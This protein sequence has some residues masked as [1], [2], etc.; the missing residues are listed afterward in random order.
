[1][2]KIMYL[3]LVVS[4][5]SLSLLGCS[6]KDSNLLTKEHYLS[7]IKLND[8]V[9][10]R[11]IDLSKIENLEFKKEINDLSKANGVYSYDNESYGLF[12][13]NK[14]KK[15]ILFNGIEGS[16]SD[17]TFSLENKILTI[18]YN[19]NTEKGLNKNSLFVVDDSNKDISY[20]QVDLYKDGHQDA[21]ETI[22]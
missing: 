2:K 13:N 19:Y 3:L 8:N 16:Y 15:M 5:M 20:D 12:S 1:M 11:E 6:K 14:N 18:R 4:I 10:L 22:Y 21:F 9:V 7:E 17:I